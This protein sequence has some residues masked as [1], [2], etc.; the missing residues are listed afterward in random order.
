VLRTESRLRNTLSLKAGARKKLKLNPLSHF[1]QR[2][3]PTTLIRPFLKFQSRKTKTI[4]QSQKVDLQ[5]KISKKERPA[6]LNLHQKSKN[7][8][9]TLQ[10]SKTLRTSLTRQAEGT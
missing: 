7:Q 10:R 2:M 8:S 6:L 1:D 5:G 3:K 9:I 4:Q